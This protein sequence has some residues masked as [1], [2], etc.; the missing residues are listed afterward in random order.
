MA[1][2]A[3]AT[4]A[5]VAGVRGSE[6]ECPNP[7]DLSQHCRNRSGRSTR[8]ATM[9]HAKRSRS[10]PRSWSTT[11]GCRG[12]MRNGRRRGNCYQYARAREVG[13][14]PAPEAGPDA[15]KPAPVESARFAS[16]A[17]KLEAWGDLRPCTFCR[18]WLPSGRCRAAAVGLLRGARDYEP[19][20][21]KQPRRC[22]GYSPGADD[23]ERTFGLHRWPELIGWQARPR[24]CGGPDL[25][26]VMQ[27]G[28]A[29]GS[30]PA[31]ATVGAIHRPAHR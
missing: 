31:M 17:A 26:W 1:R 8:R 6:I 21:P 7:P 22:I 5:T 11:A 27:T 9:T 20:I 10:A 2:R 14:S 3:V 28:E 24:D 13:Q 15:D 4:V 29:I 18:N 12:P 23:P 25:S 16:V 30:D 19:S